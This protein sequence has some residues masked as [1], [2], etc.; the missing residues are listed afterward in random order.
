MFKIKFNITLLAV[1]LIF[2]TVIASEYPT[3]PITSLGPFGA[4]GGADT[5]L[6]AMAG[7][8][9]DHLGQPFVHVNKPGG[10]STV[11]AAT[12]ASGKPDGYTIVSLVSPGAIPEIYKHFRDVP[13]TSKDLRPV[14][15]I[16]TF[17]YCL[18][19]NSS[20]GIATVDGLIKQAKAKGGS[21]SY[22]HAGRGH[23]YHLLM[24]GV[25]GKAGAKMRDVPT[26]GAGP[27]LK[28]L[29]G[30]HIDAA[31]GSCSAG[32]KFVDSGD[33]TAIAVQ[34]HSRLSWAPFDRVATFAEQGHDMKLSPWYLS[35]FVHA[36]TPHYIVQRLHDGIKGALD[37]PR[38]REI[39][40]KRRIEVDYTGP[41]G[42]LA[43][44]EGDKEVLAGLLKK[45]GFWKD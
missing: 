30:E 28:N 37:D 10:A 19:V 29:V 32:K 42:V 45:M 12:V 23:V 1:V 17:P 44:I 13:Y 38:F 34:H 9:E 36:K 27:A 16:T 20:S 24:E 4:G 7:V 6:R 40:A 35:V 14:L 31:I 5:V 41:V 21:M 33:L 8:I 18:Y 2:K 25:L 11:A 3:R 39:I 26:K 22:A 15:R 43:D